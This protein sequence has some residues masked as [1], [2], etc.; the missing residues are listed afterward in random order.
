ML[1]R[2][3]V[4]WRERMWA[5]AAG[6]GS[7]WRC[8]RRLTWPRRAGRESCWI[9]GGKAPGGDG[10]QRVLLLV[11]RREGERRWARGV[12]S[13]ERRRRTFP[14]LPPPLAFLVPCLSPTLVFLTPCLSPNRDRTQPAPAVPTSLTSN[15]PFP[16]RMSFGGCHARR[17]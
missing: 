10:Q 4:R 9:S 17:G 16:A 7:Q 11:R 12:S 3:G 8:C 1:K 6:G 5:R 13:R 15:P 14:S 2:T